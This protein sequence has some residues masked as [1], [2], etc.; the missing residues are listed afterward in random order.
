MVEKG[1]ITIEGISLTV[2]DAAGKIITVHIIPHTFSHTNLKEK[3]EGSLLNIEA[4]LLGKYVVNFL[5]K[6]AGPV[7]PIDRTFL[8][9]TGFI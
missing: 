4:D 7:S 5:E 3:Q 9:E 6:R 8:Q 1:S 2:A